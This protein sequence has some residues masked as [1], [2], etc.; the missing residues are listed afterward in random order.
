MLS[1][2]FTEINGMLFFPTVENYYRGAFSDF[3]HFFIFL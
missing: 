2:E 1:T 3:V